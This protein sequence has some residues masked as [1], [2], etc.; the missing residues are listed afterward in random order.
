[1]SSATLDGYL[2]EMIRDIVKEAVREELRAQPAKPD[3]GIDL[4]TVQEVAAI[5][6]VNKSTVRDWIAKSRIKVYRAGRQIRIYRA[7]LERFLR[8]G[9][10][11]EESLDERAAKILKVLR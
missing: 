2:R 10:A 7:E 5:A 4:L 8:S 1:M 3:T 6:K 9:N 11:S